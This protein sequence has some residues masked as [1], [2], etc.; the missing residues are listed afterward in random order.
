MARKKAEAPVKKENRVIRYFKE[1]RAELRKITWPSRRTTINLTL[2]VLGV[3]A[4]ASIALG[5][6]D[7]LLTRLVT[8]I[9]V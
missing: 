2:I 5:I 7:W 1:V 3:T 6:I 8:L 4:V 9:L